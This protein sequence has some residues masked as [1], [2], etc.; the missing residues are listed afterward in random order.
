MKVTA[1]DVAHACESPCSRHMPM[2]RIQGGI[3]ATT[4]EL[5]ARRTQCTDTM[6]A[7]NA[8]TESTDGKHGSTH[9]LNAGAELYTV[10]EGLSQSSHAGKR[11]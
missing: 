4:A 9:V 6:H 3:D 1:T 7:L 11:T 2:K 5:R 10:V 8:W